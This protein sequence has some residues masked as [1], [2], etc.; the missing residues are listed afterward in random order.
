MTRETVGR[1][2]D[3]AN[4]PCLIINALNRNEAGIP[5]LTR[6]DRPTEIDHCIYYRFGLCVPKIERNGFSSKEYVT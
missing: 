1:K 6:L 5:V 4:L 2:G 3:T